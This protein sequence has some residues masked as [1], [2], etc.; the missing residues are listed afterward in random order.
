MRKLILAAIMTLGLAANGW[1]FSYSDASGHSATAEFSLSG[2]TLSLLL[3]NTAT[4]MTAVPTDVLTAFLFNTKGTLTNVDA[5]VATGSKVI[6]A[7]Q[8]NNHGTKTLTVTDPLYTAGQDIGAEWA[9]NTNGVGAAGLD[10][11]FGSGNVIGGPSIISYGGN[12]PDGIA[13]GIASAGGINWAN[14]DFLNNNPLVTNAVRFTFTTYANFN[15]SDITDTEFVY[16]TSYNP[17]PAVPEPGTIVLL[18][19]G[20]L[21]L[22]LY[23]RKRAKK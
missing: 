1:G 2:T 16:G 20:L 7:V 3:T 17:P 14:G 8:T 5:Y 13:Y 22:G 10:G 19:A 4:S 21:G 9:Y 11:L 12:A 6:S 18:G 15:L 23:G